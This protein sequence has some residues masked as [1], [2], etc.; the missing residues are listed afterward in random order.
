MNRQKKIALWL[1]GIAAILLVLYFAVLSPLLKNLQQ[2]KPTPPIDLLEGEGYYQNGNTVFYDRGV[3]YP[4]LTYGDMFRVVV[5]NTEGEE[6]LF[7]HRVSYGSNYFYMGQY[8]GESYDE[9]GVPTF[10]HPQITDSFSGFDYTTLYDGKSKIPAMLTAVGNVLFSE[11]VYIMPEGTSPEEK[12]AALHRYALGEQDNA[13][14][15]EVTPF[16][17]DDNGNLLYTAPTEGEA[18]LYCYNPADQKYYDTDGVEKTENGYTYDKD[19]LY[20]GDTKL[21]TP[22]S[23]ETDAKRLYV[24]RDL[25]SGDGYYVRLAGRDVVYVVGSVKTELANID[26]AN[27]VEKDLS[28][29]VEP[30][31]LVLPNTLYDPFYTPNLGMFTGVEKAD[32]TPVQVG[33]TVY[34]LN[35]EGKWTRH[36]VTDDKS[37]PLNLAL[38]SKTAG[39]EHILLPTLSLA[40]ALDGTT[41]HYTVTN[42]HSVLNAPYTAWSDDLVAD[43]ALLLVTFKTADGIL[44]DGILSLVGDTLSQTQKAEFVGKPT[45]E[46]QI[47]LD[48]TY[49]PSLKVKIEEVRRGLFPVT[50]QIAQ[51]DTV[52]F[53]YY[54]EDATKSVSATLTLDTESADGFTAALSR[55]LLGKKTDE[56]ESEI[57]FARDLCFFGQEQVS[58]S[59]VLSYEEDLSFSFYY[60]GTGK[61][62]PYLA[63]SIYQITGPAP[64]TSY[65]IDSGAAQQVLEIFA[66]LKGTE[67]VAVGL[68]PETMKTYGLF[69]RRLDYSL[70]YNTKAE[71]SAPGVVSSMSCDFR[72]DYS[73]YISEPKDGYRYVATD[74]YGI[75][76]KVEES[77]LAFLDWDFLTRFARSNLLLMYT[78]DIRQIEFIANFTD[79]KK[80][81]SFWL[82]LDPAY[83][84]ESKG[85]TSLVERLYVMYVEGKPQTDAPYI[86]PVSTVAKPGV[87]VE[88][89]S[90]SD[91]RVTKLIGGVNLDQLFYDNGHTGR[92]RVDFMGVHYFRRMMTAVYSTRYIGKVSDD[93]SQSQVEALL[94]NE[95]AKVTE[96]KVTLLDGRVFSYSFYAYSGERMLVSLKGYD[97]EG[98]LTAESQLFYVNASEVKKM[99]AFC[100]RLA[101]GEPLHE[102]EGY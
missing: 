49:T 44:R 18:K 67:T 68:S 64:L 14:W 20:E 92:D 78:S 84:Y 16:L 26:L 77:R 95:Q 102:D 19:Y 91:S 71:E 99:S 66:D 34:Y 3:I 27:L 94:T 36:L 85:E 31:L 42:I 1:L 10:Y 73:F 5:H 33:D 59:A 47:A 51:G 58:I 23:D 8:E 17:R 9:G 63:D 32:G 15:I 52:F 76:V 86:A 75:V 35:G 2:G 11:R 55:H 38:L 60:Y 79:Y 56:T 81:H 97:R 45:G 40:T 72:M 53:S 87:A 6:Y 25:P 21:L 57:P 30:N 13:P 82:S 22:A 24:G 39:A 29:Y 70:T 88:Y 83:K 61:K 41:A 69:A 43:G 101:N 48:M 28:Y 74:L 54:Q 46:C 7:Y 37:N 80:H 4:T 98:N 50:G 96:M 90:D 89:I 65:A 93:L 12:E 62:D 100:R